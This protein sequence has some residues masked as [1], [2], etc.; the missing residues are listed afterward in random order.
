MIQTL[1]FA[2][3]PAGNCQ[4]CGRLTSASATGFCSLRCQKQHTDR[5]LGRSWRA[6]R[7]VKARREAIA[8]KG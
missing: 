3:L 5:L 8:R 4:G 1:S 7:R 2:N 6:D